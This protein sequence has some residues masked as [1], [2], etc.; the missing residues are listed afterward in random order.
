LSPAGD[1]NLVYNLISERKAIIHVP[2]WR[3]MCLKELS[4]AGFDKQPF[5]NVG[6]GSRCSCSRD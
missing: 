3:E 1:K 5:A 2:A 6:F 4:K